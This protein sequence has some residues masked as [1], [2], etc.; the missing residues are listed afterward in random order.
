MR[1]ASRPHVD[2]PLLQWAL[3]RLAEYLAGRRQGDGSLLQASVILPQLR[4]CAR[5]SQQRNGATAQL[6]PLWPAWLPRTTPADVSPR[7][8]QSTRVNV[9]SGTP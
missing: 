3:L 1:V 4:D 8:P 6:M 2:H 5:N 9:S 7:E